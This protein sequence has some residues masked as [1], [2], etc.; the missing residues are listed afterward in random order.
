MTDKE[1]AELEKDVLWELEK[2][3]QEVDALRAKCCAYASGLEGISR[4]FRAYPRLVTE[5]P[6]LDAVYDARSDLKFIDRQT[7]L[8]L[9]ADM[10]RA[11]DV[12]REAKRQ[13]V[14]LRLGTQQTRID[15]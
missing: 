3:Q 14:R 5:T 2:A 6:P 10:A 9:G 13:A 8:Q 1:K 15:I 4:A 7:V 11:E 12:L